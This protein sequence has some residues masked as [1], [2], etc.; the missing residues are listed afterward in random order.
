MDMIVQ[1]R[2]VHI[3]GHACYRFTFGGF[4][5]AYFVTSRKPAGTYS[6]GFLK[7]SG[8]LVFVIKNILEARDI[9]NFAQARGRLGRFQ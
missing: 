9:V 8:E 5:W 2:K 7:T 4:M 3:E 1:P 6:V